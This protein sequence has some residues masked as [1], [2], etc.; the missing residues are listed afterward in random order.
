M[1]YEI[2]DGHEESSLV[3]TRST[4]EGLRET[5]LSRDYFQVSVQCLPSSSINRFSSRRSWIGSSSAKLSMKEIC[6]VGSFRLTGSKR[7]KVRIIM[8]NS[9]HAS[10]A[11][12]VTDCLTI[13]VPFSKYIV[14]IHNTLHQWLLKNSARNFKAVNWYYW[15]DWEIIFLPWVN[16]CLW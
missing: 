8:E 12:V 14:F 16:N 11:E 2:N 6:T 4:F 15:L 7:S 1:R 10:R 3:F 5:P 9:F 13:F